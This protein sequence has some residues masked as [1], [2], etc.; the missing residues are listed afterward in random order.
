MSK[1]RGEG[2]GGEVKF[3]GG[4]GNTNVTMKL[5]IYH[6]SS[7]LSLCIFTLKYINQ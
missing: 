1:F 3:K 6:D 5:I 7:S 4:A 2:E